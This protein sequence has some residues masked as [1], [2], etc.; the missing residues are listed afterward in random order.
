M[1]SSSP[2]PRSRFGEARWVLL[3][4]LAATALAYLLREYSVTASLL[5][6]L[7]VTSM[8]QAF[9]V[10]SG[11]VVMVLTSQL[12]FWVVFPLNPY[13]VTSI[14]TAAFVITSSIFCALQGRLPAAQRREE[15]ALTLVALSRELSQADSESDVW[16]SLCK[17][18]QAE[19]GPHVLQTQRDES[20]ASKACTFWVELPEQLGRVGFRQEPKEKILL[21]AFL[22]YCAQTISH[23]RLAQKLQETELIKAR[24]RLYHALLDSLSHDLRIPLV[25][26]T[27]VLSS[28]LDDT[29][30]GSSETRRDLLENA[31]SEADR[32][33]RL[34][35]N[36]LQMTRLEA[37]ALKVTKKL[38][39][40]GEVVSAVLDGLGP[41]LQG[42][43]VQLE[44]PDDL[45]LVPQD[46]ILIGQVL[47]N[48]LDNALK[49]S[50]SSSPL[51]V[52]ASLSGPSEVEVRVLDRGRGI[53][54][55]EEKKLLEKFYRGHDQQIHG[56]GLGLSICEGLIAAHQ[57]RFRIAA[58]DGGG[59]EASF[60]LPLKVT[61][62]AS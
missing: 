39:D 13:L 45:P 17:Y 53:A 56:S 52:E 30:S 2:A 31:L 19:F 23:L 20:D 36:L 62:G 15:R 9:G 12:L 44:L 37:K 40:M 54:P 1:T 7:T 34:V 59:L 29:L 61:D 32:L 55:G 6:L 22:S 46:P 14:S 38:Y 49:Y 41:Q 35:E 57:G 51:R 25:S 21:D 43:E 5:C 11:L 28:L 60:R 3:L 42:R 24:E 8:A 16:K 48:L 50:S 10:R 26:I 27:G 4:A 58:R 47:R 33:R 18:L